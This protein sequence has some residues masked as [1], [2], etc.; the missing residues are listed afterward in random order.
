MESMC[1]YFIVPDLS[2]IIQRIH[3][4][5]YSCTFSTCSPEGVGY[6]IFR[7]DCVR[8]YD[9]STRGLPTLFSRR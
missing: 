5:V 1:M 2:Q 9:A 4:H 7:L 6:T 8:P 3:V